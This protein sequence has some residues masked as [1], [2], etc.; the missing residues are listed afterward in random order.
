MPGQVL[1]YL[2][3]PPLPPEPQDDQP[4]PAPL[5]APL[6][7]LSEDEPAP[8]QP[9][10]PPPPDERTHLMVS[11]RFNDTEMVDYIKKV[12]DILTHKGVPIFMVDTQAPGDAFGSQTLQGLYTAKALL[13]FCGTNYGQRTGARYETYVELRYAHDNNLEIIPIQLCDTFPPRPPDFEG[14]CQNHVVL[15]RDVIRI[16]DIHMNN[17]L[18]VADKIHAAWTHRLQH[19]RVYVKPY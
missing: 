16:V 10:P 4:P 3:P 14:R 5:L 11:G 12:R 2:P 18:H 13:A 19:L 15:Q 9:Q 7:P 17:P 1:P 6:P 8:G